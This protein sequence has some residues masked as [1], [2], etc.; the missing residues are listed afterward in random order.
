MS[1]NAVAMVRSVMHEQHTC[2]GVVLTQANRLGPEKSLAT[3]SGAL[4][5]H[6]DS[7]HTLLSLN[8]CPPGVTENSRLPIDSALL[9]WCIVEDRAP[10][11]PD[12]DQAT[13]SC[14]QCL[15]VGVAC[16]GYRDLT[17]IV[18]RDE[19]TEVARKAQLKQAKEPPLLLHRDPGPSSSACQAE[20][21]PGV[22]VAGPLLLY[23]SSIVQQPSTPI[24]EHATCFAH[25][26]YLDPWLWPPTL[27][28]GNADHAA[29]SASVTALGLALLANTKSSPTLM[30][31]AREEYTE[32]LRSTN[33]AL[34]DPFLSR[35]DLTLMAVMFLGMF[36]VVTCTGLNSILQWRKHIDGAV[37]LLEW[38]GEGQLRSRRGLHLFRQM[39]AQILIHNIFGES[40]TSPILTRLSSLAACGL[41]DDA[42]L[43]RFGDRLANI[44]VQLTKLCADMKQGIMTDPGVI[45]GAAL[46]LDTQLASWTSGMPSSFMYSKIPSGTNT[47][48]ATSTTYGPYTSHS[49]VYPDLLASNLWSNWRAARF[50]IHEIIMQQKD[51]EQAGYTNAPEWLVKVTRHSETV[52]RELTADIC[53]SVPYHFLAVAANDWTA[54][55]GTRPRENKVLA[56]GYSLLWPLFLVASC[57]FCTPDL[58]R[59]VVASLEKIGREMGISQALA[60]AQLVRRGMGPRTW[61]NQPQEEGDG[62]DP[63][64][65]HPGSV[66]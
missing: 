34:E 36:E 7:L 28:L 43:S 46:A 53:A 58:R 18:I 56:A 14:S 61:N 64:D 31:A 3:K 60:M 13:P 27:D 17:T 45:I 51:G 39:R 20:S 63:A 32:A 11:V 12:C 6:S 48:A 42:S 1:F 41:E 54:G 24:R 16:A 30:M 19:S 9:A 2:L 55:E 37:K 44:N 52:L 38:R 8:M 26:S 21:M 10:F 15:R 5:M 65:I 57:R 33:R 49:Y 47:W 29:A 25:Q 40:D 23:K 59:W 22:A 4:L 50:V 66:D 35:S 62:A